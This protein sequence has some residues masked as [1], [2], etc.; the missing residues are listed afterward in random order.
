[1]SNLVLRASR[2][3]R[4]RWVHRQSGDRLKRINRQVA[5]HAAPR[6]GEH[7]VVFFNASTRLMGLSLNAAYNLI[8]R[9]A[10]QLS[11]VPVINF[12]SEHGMSRCVLGT[13]RDDVTAVPPCESCIA[14]SRTVYAHSSVRQF[15]YERDPQLASA[16]EGQGL[17]DLAAFCF[18]DVPLGMLALPS[19]RWILRRHHLVDDASTRMLYAE[20]ILSAWQVYR[21]FTALLD[22]A[23]PQV[24]VVFNGMFYPE[25][26]ARWAAEQRGLPVISHEVGLRPYT[27]FFTTGDATA[28]PIQIPDS[29][30][31]NDAQNRRLDDYLERRM[32]GN[33]RM[34]GVQFWPEM[35]R[36]D[37]SFLA[38]MAQFRQVVPVF[39]NVI[40][41]TSQPHS[42]VVFP[43]MFA[44]LDEV[45]EI[46][47][48]NADTLFVIRA[49]PDEARPGK[50]S[51][52]SVAQWVER[53]DV[54]AMANVIFVEPRE[55]LS[56]Y[57]L[58]QRSKFVMIYNSTIGLEASLMG[59]AVLCAGKARFTQLPTVFFPATSDEYRQQ[60]NQFLRAEKVEVPQSFR[61]N[62]RRFLYYQLYRTSMPFD[63]FLEDDGIWQ[64]YVKV[65]DLDY[66][67]FD[68]ANAPVLRT[69]VDGI[70][71]GKEFL[72][73]EQLLEHAR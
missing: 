17:N 27:A 64:G 25:A 13:N 62:A 59:A 24:V 32:L 34:A 23:N 67:A 70:L 30:A 40:F 19:M 20:Y 54:S 35:R 6:P 4:R 44:W 41:D 16:L 8:T 56:S 51:R 46:A 57:E 15:Q 53:R 45:L 47:R 38:R 3:L 50:E 60:S 2:S 48:E 58:I 69:I 39:T 73:D 12:V 1:M 65:R 7:P 49:H 21:S 9:W 71:H 26:T 11:G 22:D 43:D 10:V 14:Q 66:R 42:N 72:L 18:Q 36:L 61:A 37:E 68:P 5:A 28:Y 63:D 55:Y 29:F 52:E 33:F 31:L